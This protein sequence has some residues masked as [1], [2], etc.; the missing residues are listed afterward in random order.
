MLN[1]FL[2]IKLVKFPKYFEIDDKV[3]IV[4]SG[5]IIAWANDPKFKSLEIKIC[6]TCPK[7][8]GSLAGET[9][10][11]ERVGKVLKMIL[12]SPLTMLRRR[13]QVSLI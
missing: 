9:R 6:L 11:R 5:R 8:D 2:D 1:N 13:G 4:I 12:F 10:M 7:K 3:S